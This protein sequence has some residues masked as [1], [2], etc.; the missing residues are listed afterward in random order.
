MMYIQLVAISDSDLLPNDEGIKV[1]ASLLSS[2][3]IMSL[4][5]ASSANGSTLC[6]DTSPFVSEYIE[7]SMAQY[8][9]IPS[10]NL[11]LYLLVTNSKSSKNNGQSMV[12]DSEWYFL[13]HRL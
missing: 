5:V 11:K 7:D 2:G 6:S 8:V 1:V 3:C 12:D 10:Y 4:E 13:S 9:K